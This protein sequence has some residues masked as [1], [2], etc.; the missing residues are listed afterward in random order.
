[1][2]RVP[3]RPTISEAAAPPRLAYGSRRRLVGVMHGRNGWLPNGSSPS[4]SDAPSSLDQSSFRAPW[5]E[6]EGGIP[7]VTITTQPFPLEWWTVPGLRSTA[8]AHAIADPIDLLFRPSNVLVEPAPEPDLA[9][10]LEQIAVIVEPEEPAVERSTPEL[11]TAE[12]RRTR[13]TT[14]RSA[15][16]RRGLVTRM[17]LVAVGLVISLI[18]V[19]TATRRRT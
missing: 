14:R 6:L 10:E 2:F 19:E 7:Y 3:A 9:V 12:A 4:S 5:G 1:M 15:R 17:V 11:P 13:R 18:A 16:E 8:A